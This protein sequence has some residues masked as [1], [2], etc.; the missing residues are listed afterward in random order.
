MASFLPPPPLHR[1]GEIPTEQIGEILLHNI[2]RLSPAYLLAAEQ[3][4][5][6]AQHIQRFPSQDRLLVFVHFAITRLSA[7]TREPVPVVWVRARLPEVR[8][9]DLNRA[10]ERLEEENLITL[11]G[12]ETSDPRAV[13][14]GISSP[15][16]G[17]LTHIELRSPL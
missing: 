3:V 14:G 10:L 7:I 9:S 16:R 15:V 1:R 17:C 12:L 6:E 4:V 8:R 5:R 11:Y 2:F 13:A